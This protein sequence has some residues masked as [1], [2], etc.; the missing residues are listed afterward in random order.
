M[1]EKQS[2][3]SCVCI[4][5]TLQLQGV[6]CH[7][8]LHIFSAWTHAKRK[9][10]CPLIEDSPVAYRVA[11]VVRTMAQDVSLVLGRGK[12]TCRPEH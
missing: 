11:S 4:I 6:I 7:Q 10:S 1:W 8:W 2:E 9:T 5:F 3:F 12:W